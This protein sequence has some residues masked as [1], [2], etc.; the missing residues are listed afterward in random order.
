MINKEHKSADFAYITS[1][2]IAYKLFA[3]I[4]YKLPFTPNQLST[5]NFF[6]NGLPAVVFFALGKYWANIV[7]VGFIISA[8]IWDWMD[9]AVARKRN[10][11]S[12][13][14]TFLDPALDFIWQ[15]LL[16]AGIAIGVYRS[17]GGSLFWLVIGFLSLVCLASANYFIEIYDKNFGFGFRGD[18]D[19]FIKEISS[20]KRTD[21]F[22]KFML[23]ILT[24][25]KFAY[26]FTFTVRY[27][28][29][30]GA[31]FNRL[32]LFLIFLTIS[33]FVRTVALF[34]SYYL[35]LESGNKKQNKVIAQALLH[36]RRYWLAAP[37]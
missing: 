23:E 25:R 11:A 24:F 31:I 9:G 33:F 32:D 30:L 18:Y 16:V 36:R 14:G 20:S 19:G 8:V 4:F 26:I 7:A 37:H 17:T 1:E 34:Y 27:P 5:L 15:H 3:S 22:D 21:F 12:K 29:L 28:L 13:G 2:K 10:L 35:Y 6:I